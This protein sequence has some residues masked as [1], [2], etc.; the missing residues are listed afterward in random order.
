[1]PLHD[2]RPMQYEDWEL[3]SFP[4][5]AAA[6]FVAGEPVAIADSGELQEAAD[7]V[8]VIATNGIL[9]IAAQSGDTLGTT[10]GG[11][12]GNFRYTGFGDFNPSSILPTTGDEILVYVPKRPGAEVLG[13]LTT[14]GALIVAP[15][16]TDV[17]DPVGIEKVTAGNWCFSNDTSS[18]PEKLGRIVGVLDADF[19]PISISG[20]TGVWVVAAL[21]ITQTLSASVASLAVPAAIAD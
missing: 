10:P 12:V 9:G 19:N 18:G 7:P 17:G 15:V 6:T 1:M 8:V 14:D 13:K 3:R 2:L 16:Q 21:I 4:L 5:D 11:E 20:G